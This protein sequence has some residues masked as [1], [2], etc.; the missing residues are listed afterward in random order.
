[1]D[2][3]LLWCVIV[4]LGI[5]WIY[6][7]GRLREIDRRL[8]GLAS[9]V[10]ARPLAMREMPGRR[11]AEEPPAAPAAE[12]TTAV[13]PISAPG[14]VE[15]RT[16]VPSA[17]RPPAAGAPLHGAQQVKGFVGEVHFCLRGGRVLSG[18][19]EVG[20]RFGAPYG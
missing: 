16:A 13:P 18:K 19:G 8:D 4:A 12:A 10:Y 14:V 15:P 6:L 20:K 7:R 3:L 9:E 5:A 11:V 2:T 17:V 1:M